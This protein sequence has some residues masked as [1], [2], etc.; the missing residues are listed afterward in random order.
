MY[1]PWSS[2]VYVN[3]RT[4]AS[5]YLENSEG[6]RMEELP[7]ISGPREKATEGATHGLLGKGYD[8]TLGTKGHARRNLESSHLERIPPKSVSRVEEP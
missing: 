4:R 6:R 1:I 8:F 5:S 7:V 3:L 2:R